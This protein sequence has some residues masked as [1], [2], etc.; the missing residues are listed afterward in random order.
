MSKSEKAAVCR[1]CG[2]VY[3]GPGALQAARD[4]ADFDQADQE[5]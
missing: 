1:F 4:C 3:Y 5:D 2:Q